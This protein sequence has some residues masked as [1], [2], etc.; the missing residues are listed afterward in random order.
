MSYFKWV[1][2]NLKLWNNN[3]KYI[4]YIAINIPLI[5]ADKVINYAKKSFSN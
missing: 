4:S 1:I 5:K 3:N 2:T